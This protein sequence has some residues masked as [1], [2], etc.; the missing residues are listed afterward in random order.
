MA[1]DDI[2]RIIN[3]ADEDLLRMSVELWA[4]NH[5]DFRAYITHALITHALNPHVSEIDFDYQLARA[6]SNNTEL[7]DSRYYE[8]LVVDWSGIVYRLIEPWAKEAD[9]FSTERLQ[10]LV[11]AIIT[12][13]GMKVQED[14]FRGD[15]WYGDNYSVQIEEIMDWLGHFSGLL[16]I[17]EDLSRDDMLSLQALVKEVQKNDIIKSYIGGTLYDDILLMIKMRL[18]TEEVACGIFDLMIERDFNHKA[19]EWVCR[20]ID[21]IRGMGLELEA[22]E[23]MDANLKYPQVLVKLYH[24]LLVSGRWQD[25]IIILDK[26]NAMSTDSYWFD[27]PNWLEMKS[28]LLKEHGDKQSQIEVLKDLFHQ[29]WEEKYYRQLKEMVDADEWNQFCR[30]L[31]K[32]KAN[33]FDIN[34]V[35]PFLI[36]ENEFDELYQLI[37]GNFDSHPEDYQIVIAYAKQLH[38]THEK[39][40]QGLIVRSFRTYAALHFAP[41]QKVNSLEYTF[42]CEDLS[43]LSNMG[44]GK[45]QRELV[46]IFLE[47][48]RKRRSFVNELK[49]IKLNN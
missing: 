44:F 11:E 9:C 31:L 3:E 40:L 42:F 49:S 18:E 36:E 7:I 15:D 20:K 45:E 17:R 5:E 41:G 30:T 34:K 23:Y 4:M 37:K 38:S 22:Q 26:A 10:K 29:R 32:C 27:T 43:S 6:I 28:D 35:A 13:V 1:S 46:E 2:K 14:D 21:F 48:Y 24:E 25:A 39:E 19:G 8:R 16:L 12:E 33:S 47:E